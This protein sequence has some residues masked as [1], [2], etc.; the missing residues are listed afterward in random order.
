METQRSVD[1]VDCIVGWADKMTEASRAPRTK[2]DFQLFENME[3]FKKG[4]LKDSWQCE[5][6]VTKEG[7]DALNDIMFGGSAPQITDWFLLL[8][9]S[10]T[11]PADTMTYA[12]PVFTETILYNES[13]RPAFVCGASADQSI[14]NLSS[15]AVFT[16][17][18]T[19][20]IYGCGMVGG[21]TDAEVKGNVAGG[22]TLYCAS[23]FAVAKPVI[24]TN[25][26]YIGMTISQL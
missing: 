25:V 13:T 26:L 3:A 21:G 23:K 1:N 4:I 20:T 8:F 11:T 2:W 9:S 5:N 18:D 10:D 19:V 7:K 17:N 12:V 14:T 15:R 24:A 6:L 16:M 22:G